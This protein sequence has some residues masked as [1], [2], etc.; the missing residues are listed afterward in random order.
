[1]YLAQT[2]PKHAKGIMSISIKSEEDALVIIDSLWRQFL[3]E[4]NSYH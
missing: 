4:Q 1:M 2:L 3:S